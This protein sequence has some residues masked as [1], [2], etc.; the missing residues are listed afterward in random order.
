MAEDCRPGQPAAGPAHGVDR[1]RYAGT[2]IPRGQLEAW[3]D[4]A[5]IRV[6]RIQAPT[7]AKPVEPWTA[8]A[9]EI[10]Y[11][12]AVLENDSVEVGLLARDLRTPLLMLQVDYVGTY[13]DAAVWISLL[14]EHEA[15][16]SLLG[17]AATPPD[18]Q[19]APPW[20]L[21][22]EPPTPLTTPTLLVWRCEAA[23]IEAG[24][25][26]VELIRDAL[27]V[28]DP[29]R[30]RVTAIEAGQAV[31]NRRLENARRVGERRTRN[32]RVL[33]SCDRCGRDLRDPIYAA[34]GIGPEC[35]KSYPSAQIRE[36][37]ALNA[38]LQASSHVH[39][40]AK[41]PA[42][43]LSDLRQRWRLDLLTR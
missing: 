17:N 23:P 22:L 10:A 21:P 41:R 9:R 6:R 8:H 43:W 34:I 28:A 12:L 2:P 39:L 30:V 25:L 18:A 13:S 14:A 38:T 15:L 3:G 7:A 11:R 33:G 42:S 16:A 20:R 35:I 24:F 40:N 26:V 4:D 19:V 37:R 29:D 36:R 32:F 27:E 1:S 31:I 5:E